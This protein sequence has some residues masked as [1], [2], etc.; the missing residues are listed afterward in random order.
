MASRAPTFSP[1]RALLTLDGRSRTVFAVA[2]TARS[3]DLSHAVLTPREAAAR[4]VDEA[5]RGPVA[6]VLGP[7]KYGLK[8]QDVNRCSVIA[9]VP[10][11]PEYSSL[12]L[13]AAVQLFAYELRLAAERIEALPR[14]YP[15]AA[16]GSKC[17]RAPRADHDRR[18]LRPASCGLFW[19]AACSRAP[20]WAREV[21][22]LRGIWPPR[23]YS[24]G[25]RVHWETGTSTQQAAHRC[26]TPSAKTSVAFST[27]T[28][29]RAPLKSLP[30]AGFPRLCHRLHR[31]WGGVAV[32]GAFP[33][34]HRAG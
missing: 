6:L 14:S 20:A 32:A 12:N 19:R 28:P 3:R 9:T 26:W 10:A 24:A 15:P 27:A 7:E 33:V 21:N 34:A 16:R 2:C 22:I 30:V 11:N 18:R 8:G 29:L 1:P 4:M 17:S 25:K 31:L 5:R 13:A 23:G